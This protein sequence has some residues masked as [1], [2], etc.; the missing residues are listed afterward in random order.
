MVKT[1]TSHDL[2]GG[3]RIHR[4]AFDLQTSYYDMRLKNE[5]HYDPINFINTNFDPTHRYG[6]ETSFS[7]QASETVRLRGSI[8]YTRAVFTEGVFAGKDQPLVS[9]VSGTAGITW[10]IWQNYLVL[11]AQVRAWSAR[12]LDADEANQFPVI[13]ANATADFKLS[14]KYD[15]FFWSASVNNAFNAMYYDYGVVYTSTLFSAY[16]LPGRTYMLKAGM[17]F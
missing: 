6:S 3:I 7:L 12:R 15:R 9:P 16:P 14:G 5:L 8:A 1:Q 13:G 11:D 2:E 10:N 17:T 4:G